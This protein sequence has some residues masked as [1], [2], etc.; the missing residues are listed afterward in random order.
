MRSRYAL[1]VLAILA[2]AACSSG[3]EQAP[4]RSS[5]GSGSAPPST[6]AAPAAEA[7][8]SA[9]PAIGPLPT[10]AR[11]G[12]QPPDQAMP[13]VMGAQGK[14]VAILWARHDALHVPPLA[15]Q[16]NKILWVSRLDAQA[17]APLTIRATLNGSDRTAIRELPNGPGPSY[18]NLPVAGC[19]TLSLSWSGH[20]DRVA[21]RYVPG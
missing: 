17:G 5:A 12:F 20:R 4:A 18:V 14:I 21:L 13:H 6:G 19:W 9:T 16:A 8:C 1:F 2:V 11:S 15:N 7:G 10:W 3:Q